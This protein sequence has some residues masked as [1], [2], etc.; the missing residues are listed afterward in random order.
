MSMVLEFRTKRRLDD[1]ISATSGFQ[2]PDIPS[3]ASTFRLDI[4]AGEPHGFRNFASFMFLFPSKS[5]RILFFNEKNVKAPE[6]TVLYRPSKGLEK[7][8]GGLACVISMY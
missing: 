5:R 7:W 6:K 2:E 3:L 8:A 1:L 4:Q